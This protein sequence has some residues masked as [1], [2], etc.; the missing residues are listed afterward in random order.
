MTKFDSLSQEKEFLAL[1]AKRKEVLVHLSNIKKSLEALNYDKISL[2]SFDRIEAKIDSRQE[3]LEA[4]TGAVSVY[5]T[6]VGGDPTNDSGFDSY[7]EVG[8]NIMDEIDILREEYFAQLKSKGLLQATEASVSQS[9][10]VNA[11]KTL[12]E[13]SGKHAAATEN[14]TSAMKAI[15]ESS[16]KQAL[17][18]IQ[19]HKVPTM[20]LTIFNPAECRGNPLVGQDIGKSLNCLLWTVLTT[21]PVYSFYCLQLRAMPI[22]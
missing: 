7:C 21:S 5:L 13:S 15:A 19:H 18:S 14:Q 8:I 10:L 17:A 20:N 22:T 2:R 11:M 6:K 3:Q 16:A 1:E 4:A 12:A 9:D